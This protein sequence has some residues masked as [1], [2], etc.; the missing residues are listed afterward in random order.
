MDINRGA[1]DHEQAASILREY[2]RRRQST[3]A[4][5]EWFS[6]DPPFPD[7][8]FGDPRLVAG[9]YCN[10]GI[11]PLAGG[12]IARAAFE[13][14]FEA[15][16]VEILEQYHRL[17]SANGETYLWYFPDGTAS[18]VETSTS[19]DALPTDGWGSSAMLWALVEGLA[20]IVDEGRGFDEV[21]LSPR[22]AAA[23]VAEAAVS[24]RYAASERGVTYEYR[25]SAERIDIDVESGPADVK[26]HV[27]IPEGAG[28]RGV[29][30]GTRDV[31]FR[32]AVIESSRYADFEAH[33]NGPAGF[34]ISLSKGQRDS[35]LPQ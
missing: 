1:A 10:G 6:I 11:M 15:Y 29:R 34:T 9:A 13:H 35:E 21:A 28:V 31:P 30:C 7:G 8:I 24:A 26:L 20:G 4:F 12:E 23:G 17:I 16:G 25:Q 33:L 22:W 18:S 14:G 2:R 19:P 5:A 3:G 32:T 27:L